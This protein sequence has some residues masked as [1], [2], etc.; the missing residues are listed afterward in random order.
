[1]SGSIPPPVDFVGRG[2][3]LKRGMAADAAEREGAGRGEAEGTAVVDVS[4]TGR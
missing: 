4:T 2:K 1:M 3:L